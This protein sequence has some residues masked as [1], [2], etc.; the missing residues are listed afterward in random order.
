MAEGQSMKTMGTPSLERSL[1]WRWLL[2]KLFY[3]IMELSLKVQLHSELVLACFFVFVSILESFS[4]FLLR[5]GHTSP[6]QN[7]FFVMI[8]FK[9]KLA[10]KLTL[11]SRYRYRRFCST[12]ICA[13]WA[14]VSKFSRKSILNCSSSL[15][16]CYWTTEITI[17][18]E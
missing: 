7:S 10:L 8:N 3:F 1:R 5:L 2:T 4:W 18:K 15:T 14:D 11:L 16:Q 6:H 9:F 12:W 13:S 17:N